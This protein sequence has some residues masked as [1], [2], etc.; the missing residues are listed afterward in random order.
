MHYDGDGLNFLANFW[1]LVF[2]LSWLGLEA[3][4]GWEAQQRDRQII[5]LAKGYADQGKDIPETVLQAL[6]QARLDQ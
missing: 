3:A 4:K 2:P 6:R 5:D 1:W